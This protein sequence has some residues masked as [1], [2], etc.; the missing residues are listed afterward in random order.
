M[1]KWKIAGYIGIFFAVTLGLSIYGGYADALVTRTGGKA[2]QDAQ[3][4]VFENT[5]SYVQG[6]RQEASKLYKE[7]TLAKSAADKAAIEEVVR[8]QFSNFDENKYLAG[9]V[10]SFIYNSKY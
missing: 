10:A 7:W 3:R 9:P 2:K 1:S 6:K 4:V 8:I 5:Q